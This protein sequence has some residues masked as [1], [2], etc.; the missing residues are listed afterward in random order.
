MKY[1]NITLDYDPEFNESYNISLQCEQN[2]GRDIFHSKNP[3]GTKDE[4]NR[5]MFSTQVNDAL[6]GITSLY[7]FENKFE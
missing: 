6:I 1:T 7:Y 2:K 3:E 4:F 5:T